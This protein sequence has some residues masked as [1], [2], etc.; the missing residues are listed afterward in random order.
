[1]VGWGANTSGQAS[2]PPGATNVIAIEG[3]NRHSLVLHADGSLRAWGNNTYGQTNIPSEASNIIAISVS[4]DMTLALRADGLVIGWGGIRRPVSPEATNCIAVS[5]GG[6]HDI[7]LRADRTILSWVSGSYGQITSPAFASNI[8]AIAA[9]GFHNLVLVGDPTLPVPPRIGR[10]PFGRALKTGN[11]VVFNALAVGGLPFHCQWYQDGL[12][13][14]GK[15]NQWFALSSAHP[16]DAGNYQLVAMND[17]GS[18]TSAVAFVSVS[19]PQPMLKSLTLSSNGFSFTFDSVAGV[20]YISEFKNMLEP[21]AWTELERRFGAGTT[22]LVTDANAV[23]VAR[24]YRVRALFVRPPNVSSATLSNGNVNF[25]FPTSDGAI[26]VVQYKT[27]L[28]DP[29]WL[30]LLRQTGTGAPI[31]VN[32]PNPSSASR[33]YRVKVE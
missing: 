23:D 32:D 30:E 9:G 21:G 11:N 1:M 16:S 27:N 24:Y 2:V 25:N 15:T 29:V 13:L 14:P 26:Y 7:A 31:V 33:F 19:I 4:G 17:F 6:A 18:A 28:N 20:I 10:P 22:E 8:M 5:A 3:G 12:P